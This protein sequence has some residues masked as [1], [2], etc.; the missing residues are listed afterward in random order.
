MNWYSELLSI[1]MKADCKNC[2]VKNCYGNGEGCNK[3]YPEKMDK[4]LNEVETYLSYVTPKSGSRKLKTGRC[5]ESRY[6]VVQDDNLL[7]QY[8]VGFINDTLDRI[9]GSK[10]NDPAYVFHL[11]QVKDIIGFENIKLD[12]N[13]DGDCFEVRRAK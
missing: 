3:F 7:Y 11:S 6:G 1:G 4:F 9:R 13:I 5:S 8:Y 12:Y 2:D 10:R